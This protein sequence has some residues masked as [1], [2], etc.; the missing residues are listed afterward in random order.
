MLLYVDDILIMSNSESEIS[1]IKK[2]LSSSFDMKDIGIAKRIL[3]ID[4]VRDRPKRKMYLSQAEYIDK[5]LKKFNMDD[6]KPAMIPLGGHLVLSKEDRPKDETA[7]KKMSLI[8]YDVAVGSVMY[9]MLCIR[10]DLAY[11]ISVLS[12]FMSN[13]GESHWN[14]IKFLLKYLNHTKKLG[15]VFA[16]YGNKSDLIGHVD[17]DYASN[18]DTRKS[19]T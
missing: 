17:S 9:C 14:A 7:R 13:P 5:V 4:I 6:S 12:R 16:A 10:P 11:G 15:L 18:R 1:K 8:P 2:Q 3:G 19:T